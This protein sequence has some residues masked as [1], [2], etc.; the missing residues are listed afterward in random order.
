[1][2]FSQAEDL[3]PLRLERP[4]ELCRSTGLLL[5][6]VCTQEVGVLFMDGSAFLQDPA[7]ETSS[8]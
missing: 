2:N 1:M 7:M 4:I 5:D 6:D 3:R 8:W